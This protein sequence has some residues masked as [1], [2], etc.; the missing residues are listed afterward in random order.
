MSYKSYKIAIDG[1][2][3]AG[4]STK[5]KLLSKELWYVYIDTGAKYRAL[6]LFLL[7]NKINIDDEDLIKKYI[8]DVNI[9]IEYV[10]GEQIVKLNGKNVNKKIRSSQVS[11]A[12]S[13]T[14]AFKCVREKLLTL[15]RKLANEQNCVMDG[16]DIASNVIPDA[17]LKIFLTAIIDCRANRRYKEYLKKGIKTTFE[18]TKKE[19]KDRDYCDT[20]RE[21]NPLIKV[22]DTYFLD[23]TDMDIDEVLDKILEISTGGFKDGN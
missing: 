18:E 3:S 20:N 5:A 8:D 23:T 9:D 14:S 7:E 21:N 16:G 1:P 2:A 13:K 12:A 6:A 10:N 11:D 19:I 22:S 4:K 17:N 15:Q